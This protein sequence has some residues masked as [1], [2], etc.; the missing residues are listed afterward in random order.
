MIELGMGL[1]DALRSLVGH[2]ALGDVGAVSHVNGICKHCLVLL[3]LVGADR[4]ARLLLLSGAYRAGGSRLR[5]V[6][7]VAVVADAFLH[8]VFSFI[9]HHLESIGRLVSVSVVRRVVGKQVEFSF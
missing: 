2:G 5:E 4:V 1:K 7:R 9:L 3:Q 6:A 8:V